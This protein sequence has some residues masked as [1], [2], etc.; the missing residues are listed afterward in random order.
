LHKMPK[1]FDHTQTYNPFF[2]K[3]NPDCGYKFGIVNSIG[4]LV[5]EARFSNTRIANR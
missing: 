3:I 4:V 2:S 5:E 1:L